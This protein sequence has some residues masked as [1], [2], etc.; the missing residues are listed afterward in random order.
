MNEPIY[1]GKYVVTN[2]KI[3]ACDGEY[4]HIGNLPEV[5]DYCCFDELEEAKK[6][7]DY[8]GMRLCEIVLA[9][10]DYTGGEE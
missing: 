6:T 8:T 4:R 7:A 1:T 5:I 9:P 2:G 3:A 10:C